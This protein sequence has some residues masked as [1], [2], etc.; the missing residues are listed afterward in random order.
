MKRLA[1]NSFFIIIIF[2]W[3]KSETL[4]KYFFYEVST[5]TSK[6]YIFGSIHFG[7]SEWYPFEKYI[8]KAFSKSDALV[9][10]VD[11]NNLSQFSIMKR[12]F[13]TDSI[14]LRYKLKPENYQK[15]VSKLSAFGMNE[16][17]IQRIRPWFI[18][19]TFQQLE[20]K[21]GKLNSKDGVDIYF[22]RKANEMNMQTIG[23]EKIEYQLSLL[24]KFDCCPDEIIENLGKEEETEDNID[25]IIKAWLKGNDKEINKMI[26]EVA[27]ASK[28]YQEVLHEI[29]LQ[30]NK[31]MASSIEELLANRTQ[32]FIVIGAAHL[33]G[34][35]SIIKYLKKDKKK[36]KIKRL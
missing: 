36:Y 6:V 31:S 21:Q 22:T 18:A 29:L 10:E 33:V 8:E 11:I 34:E 16:S 14:D 32:Y 20:L 23:I 2:F 27:D 30:R 1:L 26:N 19:F 24:E 4:G 13:A 5:D 9:T 28:E 3:I 35:E 15:V 12:I 17:M 7:K 25:K